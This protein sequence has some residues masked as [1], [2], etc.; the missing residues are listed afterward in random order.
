MIYDLVVIGGGTAGLVASRTAAGLGARVVLI[1]RDERGPGGDCLWTGCVPSKALIAAADLAHRIRTAGSVGI[2]PREPEIDFARV[3]AHV[4]GARAAIEP[5]DSAESL[6]RDGVEVMAGSARFTGPG[7]VDVDGTGIRYRSA[8][9]ATGSRPVTPDLDGLAAAGPLTNETVWDLREQ[10]ARLAILGGGPIGCELGQAFQRLGTQVTIVEQVGTVLSKEEPE[11]QQL[12]AARL[13]ADGVDLRLAATAVRVDGGRTLVVQAGGAEQ[14]VEFDRILVA[15]GRSPETAGLGL[16]AVGVE[17]DDRGAVRVDDRLATTAK[18][19]YAAGD[20]VGAL[21]FTHVAGYHGRTVAANAL[22]HTRARVSYE[23]V[24]W[25][26]FTDPEVGRVGM[27]EAQARERFGDGVAA[28]TSDYA[29]NDRAITAG[30]PH[31]FAKL[32]ADPK[33][34]L[35]GATVAAPHGGESIAEL[36]AWVRAER[37]IADVSQTVHA[38]PTFSEGQARAADDYLRQKYLTPRVRRFTKPALALL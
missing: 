16:D 14:R 20:A 26:T 29:H 32:V 13:R 28:V 24:P 2:D 17:V 21:P 9:I 6:R 5:E 3:M 23:S 10:P 11:A 18:G 22:L 7:Q 12:I 27:T 31:G 30:D 19:V 33:G 34:R 36:A 15:A 8:L 38:Y 1:D 25:T 35:V 4:H 37:K